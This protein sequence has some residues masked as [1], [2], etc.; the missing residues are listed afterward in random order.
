MQTSTAFFALLLG[1]SVS[2]CVE[3]SGDAPPPASGGSSGAAGAAAGGGAGV[4]IEPSGGAGGASG[5][6]G[7]AV[8]GDPPK[9]PAPLPPF[10]G[11]TKFV[12]NT[13][14]DS[15]DGSESSPFRTITKANQT[16]K[17][18]DAICLRA[19]TYAERIRPSANGTSAARITYAAYG[20]EKVRVTGADG[21]SADL[22]GKA[23]VTLYRLDL[24]AAPAVEGATVIAAG[25]SS[26]ELLGVRVVNAKP[27]VSY[28]NPRGIQA[29]DSSGFRLEQSTVSGWH[30]G[31]AIGCAKSALVRG[32]AIVNNVHHE[33]VSGCSDPTPL[34]QLIE[35]NLL[36][37]SLTSDGIQTDAAVGPEDVT[38]R[39]LIIRGNII[40]F[41]AENAI[42]LKSAGDVVIEG[43]LITASLGDNDGTGIKT[44]PTGPTSE[45][46]CP[47]TIMHG[48]N[49][50]SG[51][52]I[53]RN[54][55]LYD[56]C[57]GVSLIEHGWHTYNN[58]FVGNNRDFAG[59]NSSHEDTKPLFVAA[60]MGFADADFFNNLVV[61]QADAA[62]NVG[63]V[64]DHLLDHNLYFEKDGAPA[65]ASNG[66]H[67][68][69]DTWRTLLGKESTVTGKE[70]HSLV[71]DPLFVNVPDVPEFSYAHADP[72]KPAFA[73]T[74]SFENV[75]QYFP[76]D[77]GLQASSPAIDRGR[78]QTRAKNAGK[79]SQTLTVEQSGYFFDGYGVA[80][81]GDLLVIGAEAAVRVTH[82][83]YD[84]HTLTLAEPRSWVE[85]A[86]VSLPFAGKS[87]DIGACELGTAALPCRAK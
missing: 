8:V 68:A 60:S 69:F 70:A 36:G 43:N 80:G 64:G 13:G 2:G 29:G 58:T 57:G 52:V 26:V 12:A 83:D 87:P 40:F 19:G 78:F 24:S 17:A 54:N 47:A 49:K 1:T 14:S 81:E 84:S 72:T 20:E 74:I 50:N 18:G 42:D 79:A 39:G 37:G 7:G 55:V 44:G 59:P 65:F 62:I 31:L 32:N 10:E 23:F 16:A 51:R 66:A 21:V 38:T 28:H 86:T 6:D 9:K 56:N 73:P 82:V 61:N 76:Y 63:F 30:I 67:L 3:S 22:T 34:G 4:G 33:L 27:A 45:R 35:G 15:N 5:G 48:S 85:T 25:S 11:C 71:A 77:F 41:N 53:I 75:Q 46:F